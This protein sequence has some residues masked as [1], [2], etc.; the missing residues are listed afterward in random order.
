MKPTILFLFNSSNYAVQPWLDDGRFNVVSV[1]YDDTDHSESHTEE[2]QG[3][4]GHYRLDIDLGKLSARDEVLLCLSI[5]NMAQPS[6]VVSFAPCTDLAVSGAAHFK[7]KLQKDPQCQHR[8]V[9]MAQLASHFDCPYAVENPVSVLSTLWRKPDFYWHPWHF[10][11]DCPTGPHPEFP[12]V[13]PPQDMYN[14]KSCLWTGNGFVHPVK[15]QDKGP[16]D[17]VFPGHQKLGG[18]SAR[19]KYIRSLTPRGFAQ[20]VYE[21]NKDIILSTHD[22]KSTKGGNITTKEAIKSEQ[23]DKS[24]LQYTLLGNISVFLGVL[25]CLNL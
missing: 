3:T 19:T 6:L 2:P 12:E 8:A 7:K 1:D 15:R 14:K 18:K 23:K 10:A 16:D 17:L 13:I 20:A 22:T 11:Q 9:R 5:W 25:T 24:M 4:N 21:A